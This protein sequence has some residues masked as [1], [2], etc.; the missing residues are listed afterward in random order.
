MDYFS[1]CLI[2]LGLAMDAFAVS[3]TSGVTIKKFQV[4]HAFRIALFF[5]GFQA[6]MPLI[7]WAAGLSF[8]KFIE[9]YDHWIAFLILVIIGCK[10]IYEAVI[11]NRLHTKCDPLNFLVLLGLAIATS[12]DALAVGIGFSILNITII[13]PVLIIGFITFILSFIGVYLGDKFG[14]VFGKRIDI[15]GGIILIGIGFKIL[16]SHLL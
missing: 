11:P 16:L 10:M 7:G 3:I 13:E 4:S 8:Q 14:T 15:L 9:P 6:I 5:G 2:G 12:I 1:L